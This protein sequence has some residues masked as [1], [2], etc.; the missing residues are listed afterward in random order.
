M[1]LSSWL[2]LLFALVGSVLFI[3]GAVLIA[4]KKIHI[5]TVLPLLLGLF[6]C[7]Y[8]F[9]YYHIERFFFYHFR[10]HS[11]WRFGWLCFWIWLISLGYFFNYLAENNSKTQTTP[12]YGQ[13]LCWVVVLKMD[14][15]PLPLPSDWT[16][17][18]QWP[19][20]NLMPSW[21]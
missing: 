7:V 4:F 17:L 9:F 15:H 13:L 5:G 6:F 19:W 11:I 14:S 8:A 2:R 10:L 21:F 1:Q 12:Q 18:L 3:D 16:E 20:P